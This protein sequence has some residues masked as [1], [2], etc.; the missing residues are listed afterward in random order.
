MKLYQL[1]EIDPE[2][3]RTLGRAARGIGAAG[4]TISEPPPVS[5]VQGRIEQGIDELEKEIQKNPQQPFAQTFRNFLEKEKDK[6]KV[7]GKIGMNYQN[8]RLIRGGKPNSRYI[9]G[10]LEK[11][12]NELNN[13]IEKSSDKATRDYYAKQKLPSFRPEI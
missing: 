6:V 8:D 1:F 11:F 3:G 2:L 13:Y 4:Q 7:T 12:Y 10:V 9:R 5:D